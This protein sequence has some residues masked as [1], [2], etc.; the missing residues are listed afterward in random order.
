M[1][2]TTLAQQG[3]E[4]VEARR[5]DEAVEK[6][7][8]ALQTSPNP[9][10]LI[11]RSKA[12]IGL[13]RF[14]AALDDADLAWHTAFQRNK[15]D[16]M[17]TAQYRRGVAFFRLKQYANADYCYLHCMRL[18][19]GGSAVPKEDP[20]L[21]HVDENGFWTATAAEATA[22]ARNED[23]TKKEET[24]K[25]AMGDRN[26][27]NAQQFREWRMA[28]TMRIQAL[29]AMEKLPADDAARKLTTR[30]VPEEKD[31]AVH[32]SEKAE[33]AAQAK[34]AAA[35]PAVPETFRMQ[36]FQT[37]THMSVSVFSKGVNKEKLKV[38]FSETSV[39]LDP[40]VYSNGDEAQLQLDLWGQIDPSRSTY[41]VTPNK[42]ELSLAKKTPGKWPVLQAD[43]TPKPAPAPTAAVA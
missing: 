41:T 19:K 3:L 20:A 16:L 14:D 39:R 31:L 1:S 25:N 9:A 28:S 24:L 42:V 12:L 2:Y 32:R 5:W 10:W 29:A 33:A 35:K 26:A 6:L 15:R 38:D 4:A 8:A 11:A 40:L 30:L 18:I 43:G 27:D 17:A 7:S 23:I 36:D 34:P 13:E 37:N 22:A 21:Q